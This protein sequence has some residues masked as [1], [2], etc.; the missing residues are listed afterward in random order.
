M[1]VVIP[2]YLILFQEFE[3]DGHVATETVVLLFVLGELALCLFYLRHG[4]RVPR[5]QLERLHVGAVRIILNS[6]GQEIYIKGSVWG[7]LRGQ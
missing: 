7:S 3:F 1:E 2:T 4:V 6:G 5:P